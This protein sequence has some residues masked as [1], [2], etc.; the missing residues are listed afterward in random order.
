[1]RGLG[2]HFCTSAKKYIR[3]F[4]ERVLKFFLFVFILKTDISLLHVLAKSVNGEN[5]FPMI[6]SV[7]CK[8][9]WAFY[10]Y[11]YPGHTSFHMHQMMNAFYLIQKNESKNWPTIYIKVMS[12]KSEDFCN[13]FIQKILQKW[14]LKIKFY[15]I[16]IGHC[17]FCKIFRMKGSQKLMLWTPMN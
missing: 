11:I 8:A 14:N 1:M 4:I 7:N 9:H 6:Q 2:V 12:V 13:P 10:T 16:I 15:D 3:H 5:W 17:W